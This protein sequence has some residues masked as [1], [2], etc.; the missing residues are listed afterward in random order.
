ML[1]LD[2]RTCFALKRDFMNLRIKF[3]LKLFYLANKTVT[4]QTNIGYLFAI[5]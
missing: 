5:S 1:K 4:K 2:R 3:L